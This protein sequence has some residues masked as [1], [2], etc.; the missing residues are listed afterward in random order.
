M[1]VTSFSKKQ[2]ASVNPNKSPLHKEGGYAKKVS[3]IDS[4]TYNKNCRSEYY[5]KTA[6]TE[7]DL[8]QLQLQD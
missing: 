1:I 2:L 6:E 7:T 4:P 3:S 8:D 5:I